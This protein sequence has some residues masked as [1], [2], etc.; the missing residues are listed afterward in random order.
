MTFR[1]L[2]SICI[3]LLSLNLRAQNT[4]W[5]EFEF[6]SELDLWRGDIDDFIVQSEQLR[7]Y[8][9]DG[10]NTSEIYVPFKFWDH[11]KWNF[12]VSMDFSP[13]GSNYTEFILAKD[14]T[15]N[16]KIFCRIGENGSSDALELFFNTNSIARIDEGAFSNAFQKEKF[17]IEYKNGTWTI[18]TNRSKN[19]INFPISFTE[20]NAFALKCNYSKSR[21]DLFY[22]DSIYV[23]SEALPDTIGPKITQ[24]AFNPSGI[25][26]LNFNEAIE[27]VHTLTVNGQKPLNFNTVNNQIDFQFTGK[28]KTAAL[29]IELSDSLGNISRIDSSFLLPFQQK[30][31]VIITELMV[32]PDPS[33]FL[34]NSEY[35]ELLNTSTEDIIL[36]KWTIT[37]SESSKKQLPKI[38]LK[39]SK[40][41]LLVPKGNRKL[42]P[43]ILSVY[44]V[45]NLPSLNN[46]TDVIS[47]Y[48]SNKTLVH[49]VRYNTT[50]FD[51]LS[52]GGKSLELKNKG[53]ACS[54][55]T[56][57]W[58]ESTAF[59][60][61]TP[62]NFTNY[63]IEKSAIKINVNVNKNNILL[64]LNDLGSQ[65]LL[66]DILLKNNTLINYKWKTSDSIELNFKNFIPK[67]EIGQLELSYLDCQLQEVWTEKEFLL[68]EEL[69]SGDVKINEFLI[70]GKES[71]DFIEFMNSSSKPILSNQ[72]VLTQ[73]EDGQI[74]KS[75]K[76]E[77]AVIIEPNELWVWTPSSKTLTENYWVKYPD[78]L[79]EVKIALTEEMELGL[80]SVNGIPLDRLNTAIVE[81]KSWLNS[82]E[83][84]SWERLSPKM[85]SNNSETWAPATELSNWGTP[86]KTNTQARLENQNKEYEV[87]NRIIRTNSNDP[88]EQQI[89]IVFHPNDSKTYVNATIFNRNGQK[90]KNLV[91]NRLLASEDRIF[92]NGKDENNRL[93]ATNIY[94]IYLEIYSLDGKTKVKKESVVID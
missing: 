25:H 39:A 46:T 17:I 58:K 30:G 62:G 72:I 94:L 84:A 63:E 47:V 54:F 19:T 67:G 37:D 3:L 86:T 11:S 45:E 8:A 56:S 93:L 57:T 26:T 38:E 91:S 82:P 28:E 70:N 65:Y 80:Y 60:G 81:P 2:I 40:T 71:L 78:K 21:S 31:S 24:V 49:Q 44:E 33:I 77:Q 48:D 22:F 55:S 10:K 36:E 27:E 53:N 52:D 6:P 68:P 13:S 85:E 4:F 18:N 16:N 15:T 23:F 32:D 76:T 12:T 1:L 41:A 14:T 74:K 61:G 50:I 43:T 90:V 20:M 51:N 83:N 59:E 29:K 34:P 73:L 75:W 5:G 79:Q 7:L 69:K 9:P 42:F 87:T 35:I 89:E 88:K 92:W 66:T 64:H